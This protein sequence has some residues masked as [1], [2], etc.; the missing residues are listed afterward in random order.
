MDEKY[1]QHLTDKLERHRF[2][3]E[4]LIRVTQI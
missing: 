1:Y 2:N 4:N 3:T